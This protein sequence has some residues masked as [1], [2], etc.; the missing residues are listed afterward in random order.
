MKRAGISMSGSPSLGKP[1][2]AAHPIIIDI[3]INAIIIL[4]RW[5]AQSTIPIIF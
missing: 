3:A 2:Y 1:K 4:A 5:L